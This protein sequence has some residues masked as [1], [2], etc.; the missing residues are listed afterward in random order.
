MSPGSKGRVDARR[1]GP[2]WR[3]YLIEA[4]GLGTFMMSACVFGTLLEHP[5]SPVRQ[6]VA[7]DGVRRAL[8][9]AAMGLTAMAIVYSPWGRRSGAHLNPVFTLTFFRLGRVAPRDM[10]FYPLAQFAGAG[11]GVVLSAGLLGMALAEPPVHYVTTRPG[12]GVAAAFIAEA[13]MSMVLMAMVLTTAAHARLSRWTGLFAGTMVALYIT[14][15]APISGMSMNPART[16][17]SAFVAHDWTALWLY[18][19]APLLGMLSAAQLHLTVRGRRNVPCAKMRHAEPC[20]F[21]EYA[22]PPGTP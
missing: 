2:H 17:G 19:S 12:A 14:F 21:C 18:F 6:A 22:G 11:A 4:W 5:A 20:I 15:E 16:F 1:G 13:V 9:G 8:M 7:N 3:E 10:L